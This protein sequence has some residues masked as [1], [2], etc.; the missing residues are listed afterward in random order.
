MDATT[1]CRFSYRCTFDK[2]LGIH[3]PALSVAQMS[4]RRARQGIESSMADIAAIAGQPVGVSPMSVG[5]MMTVR[6]I[7]LCI[8]DRSNDI[9]RA[10]FLVKPLEYLLPLGGSEFV[11][12]PLGQG[13]G[14]V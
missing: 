4:Q 5:H 10:L 14:E 3:W 8:H 6:T 9:L 1:L 2:S 12:R 11:R 7:G 13:V